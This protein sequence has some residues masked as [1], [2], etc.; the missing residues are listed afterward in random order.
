[1]DIRKR[2][3]I[4]ERALALVNSE[5]KYSM[6]KDLLIEL[7]ERDLKVLFGKYKIIIPGLGDLLKLL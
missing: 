1:M 2:Q 4:A 5:Q 7:E 6:L 3:G